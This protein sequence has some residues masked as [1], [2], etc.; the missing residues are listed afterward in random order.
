MSVKK[1]YYEAVADK[2]SPL[3]YQK[4]GHSSKLNI[5][6]LTFLH[7][8]KTS[9]IVTHPLLKSLLKYRD[10]VVSNQV[11]SDTFSIPSERIQNESHYSR[12]K[13]N[14]TSHFPT[15]LNE[16]VIITSASNDSS[17]IM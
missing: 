7:A 1:D 9:T 11:T 6:L 8:F 17:S 15:F 14:L 2:F 12:F 16:E 10:N 4:E 3:Y 5:F 13:M